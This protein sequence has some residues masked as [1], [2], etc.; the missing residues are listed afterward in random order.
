MTAFAP[1][2]LGAPRS[3]E[4]AGDCAIRQF[5][6]TPRSSLRLPGS[7]RAA[8]PRTP[9]LPRAALFLGPAAGNERPATLDRR[10]ATA[11]GH[12]RPAATFGSVMHARV[13]TSKDPVATRLCDKSDS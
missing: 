2:G 12:G 11:P 7:C 6:K 1:A 10:R 8:S 13:M 4:A 5:T 9:G 3:A